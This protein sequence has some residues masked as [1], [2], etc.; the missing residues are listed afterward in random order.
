MQLKNTTLQDSAWYLLENDYENDCF[1]R[2]RHLCHSDPVG[3]ALETI[4]VP[5]SAMMFLGRMPFG[6]IS[7]GQ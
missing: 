1:A 3:L 7:F 6:S 2:V 5:F 4:Y